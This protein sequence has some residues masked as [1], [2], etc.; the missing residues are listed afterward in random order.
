MESNTGFIE[1]LYV[2]CSIHPL[3]N[4]TL[5][6]LL[7]VMH[8]GGVH[9]CFI[10]LGEHFP[11][12]DDFHFK[13][14]GFYSEEMVSRLAE[15]ACSMDIELIPVLPILEENDFI[16]KDKSY[17]G[18]APGFPDTLK[19]DYEAAGLNQLYEDMVEDIFSVF[20]T[21]KSICLKFPKIDREVIIPFIHKLLD[22]VS[23]ENKK[24]VLQGISSE[25]MQKI[26]SC[27]FLE[28]IYRENEDT[29]LREKKYSLTLSD[30]HKIGIIEVYSV[31]ELLSKVHY[32]A[33]MYRYFFPIHKITEIEKYDCTILKNFNKL[34]EECWREYRK[35]SEN[36][37]MVFLNNNSSILIALLKN[38]QKLEWNYSRL[39]LA[40]SDCITFF[41]ETYVDEYIYEYF[42]AKT[43]PLEE[44]LEIVKYKIKQIKRRLS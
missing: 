43:Q 38:I 10:N 4:N 18:F 14:P 17:R 9:Y 29:C 1:G 40:A 3:N 26:G 37:A 7:D 35:V 34:R 39:T 30:D 44:V 15:M 28:D 41:T 22:A 27:L 20:G 16:I 24:V 12:S 31:F 21:S 36:L 11:W 13:T 6:D 8:S 5:F 25:E 33:I 23:L 42:Y 19:L 32:L 2:D